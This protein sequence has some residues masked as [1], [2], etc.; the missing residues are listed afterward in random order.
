MA[1]LI[2]GGAI[3]IDVGIGL[4]LRREVQR[5]QG[6]GGALALVAP[7]RV[8]TGSLLMLLILLIAVGIVCALPVPGSGVAPSPVM[9]AYWLFIALVV[10]VI[11]LLSLADLA[12]MRRGYRRSQEE[13]LRDALLGRMDRRH[14]P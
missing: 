13:A 7:L 8:V 2:V 3:L 10:G 4:L 1:W 6:S 9:I 11:F 12:L 14:D 5:W